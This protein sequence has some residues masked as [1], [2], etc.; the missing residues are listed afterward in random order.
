[1]NLPILIIGGILAYSFFNQAKA[2]YNQIQYSP[3]KII[4]FDLGLFRSSIDF[5]FTLTNNTNAQAI[6]QGVDGLL[7]SSG[8]QFGTFSIS[9]PFTIPPGGKV[10]IGA[11]I[12]LS[13]WEAAKQIWNI[14]KSGKTPSILF[15]GGV[16]TQ[17]LGRLP[18]KYDAYLG[19]DLNF[20]KKA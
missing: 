3:K 18:F 5:V 4:D 6:I 10:D 11:T 1:L 13:N 15:D 8:A 20:R 9:K 17:L 14:I 19:Q 2:A 16:T 7:F 12:T